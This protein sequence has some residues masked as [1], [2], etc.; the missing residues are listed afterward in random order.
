[1]NTLKDLMPKYGGKKRRENKGRKTKKGGSSSTSCNVGASDH[2][3]STFGDAASQTRVAEND[4]TIKTMHGGNAANVAIDALKKFDAGVPMHTKSDLPIKQV[5]VG[6]TPQYSLSPEALNGRTLNDTKALLGGAA[7]NSPADKLLTTLSGS[8]VNTIKGGAV[9]ALTPGA[10]DGQQL[11]DIKSY[12]GGAPLALI[13]GIPAL[14]LK[15][16]KR[17]SR[18]KKNKSDKKKAGGKSKK[19]KKSKKS[20][21]TRRRRRRM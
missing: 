9:L 16:T 20:R 12:S 2:A 15:P 17:S 11:V 6:G 19:S 1:M 10:V 14:I 18:S 13:G 8:G 5:T 21:K 7:V 3:L 4:N